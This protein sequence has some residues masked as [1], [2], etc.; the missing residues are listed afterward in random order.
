MSRYVK[1]AFVL[2]LLALGGTFAQLAENTARIHYTRSDGVYEG[3]KL[4]V[5]EDTTEEVTWE[6]GLDITGEDDFGVYW[7]VGLTDDAQTL[8]FII[9][10]GDEKDPGPDMFLTPGEMGYE[11]WIISGDSTLYTQLPDATTAAPQGDLGAAQAHWLSRDTVAW[12]LGELPEGAQVSL[13]Y[14]PDAGLTPG[15]NGLEGGER[16]VLEPA[17]PLG[18]TLQ[19][20]FPHLANYQ[21]F[22]VPESADVAAILQGQTAVSYTDAEGMVQDATGLQIPGVLDDLYANDQELGVNWSNPDARTRIPTLK[23]WAPTAQN[24]RLHL[25]NDATG[26]TSEVLD[27][28]QDVT[29][30]WSVTGDADWKGRYYLYEVQVYSPYTQAVET[31]L[32]T[33]PYSHSLSMNS[34]RSQIVDLNDAALQPDGWEGLE[35]PPLEAFEDVTV[36]ELHMRDFSVGDEGVPL[37]QRGT[38]LAFTHLDSNG[39]THLRNLAEAG[40]THLHLL[41]TF[42]I[43]TINEDKSEWREPEGDLSSF[44]PD[45]PRQQAAVGEVRGDD[46]YNW[47]YDP[48]HYT[49]PEGSYAT[50]PAG[51]GRVLE[52][53]QMVKAL[54]ESGLRF[55]MD[56]VYNHTN[57][58]G[59]DEKSVLDKIVP[60]YYH[61]LNADGFVETSTCCQNTATEH[62][63]MERLMIDSL[64][65]WARDYKVDGFRFDLMGHHMLANMQN[66]R[67]ALD[68]LTLEEDGV[69]GANIYV[70]GEGWNFGEVADNAR[71]VNATQANVAGTGIGTFNDRL[72]DA[73][74]G[75]GPFDSP[76]GKV[77]NQGFIS[78]LF[79]DPNAAVEASSEEQKDRLLLAA[80]QIRVGLAGNLAGYTFTDR[81]GETVTGADV[82]Y[83]GAP[84]GY[85]QDPQE[86]IVYVSAHDNETLWDISQYKHPADTVLSER[87]RAQNMGLS[88]A[89]LSQGVP[90]FHAG[91]DMLRSKSLDRDSYDSGDW[92][93][94]LD[95]TYGTNN[96]GVGLPPAWANEEGWPPMRPLLENTALRADEA[97]IT[98]AVDHLQE[99]LQIRQSSPLFRLPTAEDVQA[100]LT[101]YNTGPPQI[102]GVIVMGLSDEVGED[103]DPNYEGVVVVFN[104]T[105]EM[106]QLPVLAF[107]G[108][109]LNL[110]PVQRESGD[111]QSRFSRFSEGTFTVQPRTTA[112][113]VLE[114]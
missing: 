1:P 4:H 39:M 16:V 70:Y 22:R 30:T 7:D 57:A 84:A 40:L 108:R 62:A 91:S 75:G 31:N 34:T 32:V 69:D 74:R 98:A 104:A 18:E 66:V 21:T 52:Y 65:T 85:T 11:V 103:L 44:P 114:P 12:D 71:G 106:Q 88:L 81:T 23:V 42:D 73:V 87:V 28:E 67:E 6:N 93:N 26:E 64:L 48:Y 100:R 53:R 95:F 113:F 61:R 78:G 24:V 79:Y 83:N 112:V 51:A 15:E 5:W 96:W 45:S 14:S 50:D 105:D 36:Y 72:R 54:N 3:W 63:M 49:V 19:N 111:V 56:V 41:P 102:P 27:M 80:D 82:D 59:Q 46:G 101:F 77:T 89:A 2:C 33:D 38:Y 35:K 68:G 76:E 107:E 37:E 13:Y 8:G 110:H 60:G 58:S 43:A 20:E 109:T 29:G 17:G 97:A 90:F 86:N 94:R 92:F 10:R 9:H 47:G 99:T 55:V 25:F